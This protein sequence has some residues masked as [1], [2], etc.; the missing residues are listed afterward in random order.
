MSIRKQQYI[1]TWIALISIIAAATA[2]LLIPAF[3]SLPVGIRT[4]IGFIAWGLA[5][6]PAV[7]LFL[8]GSR[9]TLAKMI[10]SKK[11]PEPGTRASFSPSS[12]SPDKEPLN[13]QSVAGKIS[14]RTDPRQAPEKW[15]KEF[16]NMLVSEI[17]IMAGIFYYRDEQNT[18]TSLATYALPHS[19][20]PRRFV[21]GE[22]LNG[23]A[24]KNAQVQVIRNI[25]DQGVTVFSGLGS[26]KPSYL[27][28]I[29]LV[30][31]GKARAV[32][33][34]AGFRWSDDNLE[35]LFQV[36]ARKLSEKMEAA[37]QDKTL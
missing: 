17:E 4:L 13:V 7:F 19:E 18:F 2:L 16:L 11:G 23:Q 31:N 36:I 26:G 9:G 27:A 35:Q 34:I 6:V 28:F 12:A 1:F 21:E 5:V 20:G 3:R 14:R 33:E 29:P 15:G 30:A 32:I 8:A 24:A 37:E 10:H 25:P 22:G